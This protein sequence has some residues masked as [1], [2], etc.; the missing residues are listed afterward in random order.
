[1]RSEATAVPA[2]SGLFQTVLLPCHFSV[3]AADVH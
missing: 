1:M 3:R 2:S